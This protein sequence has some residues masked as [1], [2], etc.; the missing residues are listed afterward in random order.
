MSDE[1]GWEFETKKRIYANFGVDSDGRTTATAWN[2]VKP[3][4]ESSALRAEETRREKIDF[5]VEPRDGRQFTIKA[6]LRYRYAPPAND[7]GREGDAETMAE[8]FLT[9]AGKRPA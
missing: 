9:L 1:T 2:I 6:T 3:S 5:A 4:P 8:T 7:S